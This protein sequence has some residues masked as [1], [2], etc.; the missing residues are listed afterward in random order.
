MKKGEIRMSRLM[1]F[2]LILSIFVSAARIELLNL[3]Q[4]RI[5]IKEKNY[6]LQSA[7]ITLGIPLTGESQ[8][9]MLEDE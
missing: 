2:L 4:Q 5:D 9:F 6:M 3:K 7:A 1:L 8:C